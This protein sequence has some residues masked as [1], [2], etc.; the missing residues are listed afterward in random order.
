MKEELVRFLNVIASDMAGRAYLL[1][2]ASHIITF[3]LK[4]VQNERNASQEQEKVP[5]RSGDT[6]KDSAIHQYAL[7]TLQKL[8]W[9]HDGQNQMIDAGVLEWVVHWLNDLETVSPAKTQGAHRKKEIRRG[10][11]QKTRFC[12]VNA[13]IGFFTRVWDCTDHEPDFTVPWQ[14]QVSA[15]SR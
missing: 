2:P 14:A 3:L 13:D 11:F 12:I 4:V 15:D 9:S 8:S 6:K 1:V 10:K 7:A 5:R